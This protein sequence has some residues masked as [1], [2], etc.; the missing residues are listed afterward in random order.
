M[1]KKLVFEIGTEELPSSCLYEGT[2]SL[3]N[4]LSD[5]LEKNRLEFSK[6]ETFGTPRRLIAIVYEL[7]NVQ[8]SLEKIIIGPPERISFDEQGKPNQAAKGFAKG[9]GISVDELEK[10]PTDKGIYIGKKLFEK[11]KN[12]VDILPEILNEVIYSIPFSKQMTWANWQIKFARPIR[13]ILAIYG[14]EVLNVEIESL[15]SG[16][17]TYGHRTLC[18]N[19]FKIN[20]S[21][22][23]LKILEE[24]GNVVVDGEKRR[25]L[26]KTQI[27]KIEDKYKE[28]KIKVVINKDLLDEIINLVEIP[29]VLIGNFL[30]EYLVIPKDILIKAIEYHQRY[31]AILNEKGEVLPEFIVVQN[32]IS[33]KNGEIIK[34]NERVLKA[35]LSD[36]SFFYNEDKKHSWE[37]WNE[38]L[39]GVIFYS[40]LGS[41]Y[42]KEERI[43]KICNK[44]FLDLNKNNHGIPD[45]ILEFSTRA[46]M[47]C[48]TDLVTNL[49]VEFPE[50][51]GVAGR[52]YAKERNE[53]KEVYEAIF[54]HYL[55]RFYGDVLPQTTTGI[56]VSIADKIDTIAGM[57]LAG[58]TP[59]GSE[60]PFAL[61]RRALGIVLSLLENNFNPDIKELVKFSVDLY[62]EFLKFNEEKELKIICDIV[63]FI[64]A[65]FK[66]TYEK[67][68]KR[69]DI[70]DAIL[71]TGE[72]SLISISQKY[73]AIIKIINDGNMEEISMPMIR[74][75]NIIKNINLNEEVKPDLF[76]EE[77][78][79]E[80][81]EEII[82]KEKLIK[83][84]N[85]KNEYSKS[86]NLLIDFRKKVD[87]F[88]D[89]V[90]IMDKIEEIKNNRLNLV[91]KAF[92]LYMLIA[93]FSKIIVVQ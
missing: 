90:L 92:N 32:G 75:K 13:W 70:V 86:L 53:N 42:D 61:R 45:E 31:F 24:K 17:L 50:L 65:R 30:E 56:I 54:E 80:L 51:Q 1:K 84:L 5:K 52:E 62:K 58:V 79:K 67:D 35:R 71:E 87:N 29:N 77:Y 68:E 46:S 81:Y 36:A 93:D 41:M 8:N 44:I 7:N 89:K 14:E 66:F 6:I 74:C 43:R 83:N 73:E 27:K 34:G 63:D 10:I 72:F 19:P 40:K 82:L 16:N 85:S 59:S 12:T 78:E 9:I 11:G 47:L 88:F 55:P 23:F 26:I 22:E 91:K 18:S 25:E 2:Q 38:K 28:N 3:K 15:K 20:N 76:K 37:N 33:D 64:M 69:T 21:E 49:V 4:I 39:K 57:F 60:D 48:K